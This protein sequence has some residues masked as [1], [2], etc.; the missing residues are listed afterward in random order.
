MMYYKTYFNRILHTTSG[1]RLTPFLECAGDGVALLDL[2]PACDP[3]SEALS[4]LANLSILLLRNK[5]EIFHDPSFCKFSLILTD[6]KQKDLDF[7]PCLTALTPLL[8]NLYNSQIYL[9]GESALNI[10][11]LGIGSK[12]G[13]PAKFRTPVPSIVLQ[14]AEA[15]LEKLCCLVKARSTSLASFSDSEVA[16][17]VLAAD[18]AKIIE[19]GLLMYC[20]HNSLIWSSMSSGWSPTATFVIPGRSTKVKLTTL[21][22]KIFRI[23]GRLV[24]MPVPRGKKSHPTKLS[25]MELLPELCKRII[26]LLK[27]Y[28][29]TKMTDSD[30]GAMSLS[31]SVEGENND[32]MFFI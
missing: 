28:F 21:G 17:S 29:D 12:I 1:R 30:S 27:N 7:K 18:T 13:S 4:P 31:D 20:K 9:N 10:T 14:Y 26:Y 19:F 2:L 8:N 24:T 32:K 3:C 25:N 23:N 16:K 11:G 15:N 6:C 22:E 5:L